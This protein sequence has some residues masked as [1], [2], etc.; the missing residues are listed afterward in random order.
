M[1]RK[2]VVSSSRWEPM[3]WKRR[4][5]VVCPPNGNSLTFPSMQNGH[6][7]S[8]TMS[9]AILRRVVA[10]IVDMMRDEAGVGLEELEIAQL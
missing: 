5:R 2:H 8:L 1:V 7:V 3:G 10:A 4:P 6:T 9:I